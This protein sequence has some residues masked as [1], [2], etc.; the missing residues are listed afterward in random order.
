MELRADGKRM[1][2]AVSWSG[3]DGADSFGGGLQ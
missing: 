2:G 1:G 3:A